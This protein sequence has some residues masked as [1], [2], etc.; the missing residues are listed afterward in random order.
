M[1]LVFGTDGSENH[2]AEVEMTHSGESQ[3][4][5]GLCWEIVKIKYDKGP[6]V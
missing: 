6:R 5:A 1:H 2:V 3:K 4:L